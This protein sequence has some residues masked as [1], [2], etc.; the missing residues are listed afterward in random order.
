M[1][2]LGVDIATG[3]AVTLPVEPWTA[4][5]PRL[6]AVEGLR[7]DVWRAPT[8]NDNGASWQPDERYGLLRREWGLHRMRH[9]VDAVDAGAGALTVRTRVAPAGTWGCAPCTGGRPPGTGSG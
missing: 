5:T 1:P 8:D 2:E 9:R 6:Y 4:E 3:E 7:L